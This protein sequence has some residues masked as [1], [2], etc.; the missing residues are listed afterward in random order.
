MNKLVLRYICI[1]MDRKQSE[2]N[3]RQYLAK[4]NYATQTVPVRVTK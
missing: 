4:N 1:K 2:F 3:L